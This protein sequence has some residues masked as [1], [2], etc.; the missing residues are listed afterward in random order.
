[1][2]FFREVAD[3]VKENEIC[4]SREAINR[5]LDQMQKYQ[6]KI[7]SYIED[8]YVEFLPNL[9]D[10]QQFL[11]E[12][13]RLL[14]DVDQFKKHIDDSQYDLLTATEEMEQQISDLHEAALG[15]KTSYKILKIDN[16]FQKLIGL[17]NDKKYQQIIGIVNEIK[18]LL[19]DPS[20]VI[21]KR[22]DCFENMKIKFLIENELL[23][24]NLTQQLEL[25]IQLN[26]KNFRKTKSVTV[27]ITTNVDLLHE[28]IISLFNCKYNPR[29][30]WEFLLNN[31]LE[32]II[33]K[34]VSLE[35]NEDSDEFSSVILSFSTE[36]VA[37]DLRPTYQ[38][39]FKN[40]ETV[41]KGLS[42]MNIS[43]ND[44]QC[45]FSMFGEYSKEKFLNLLKNNCLA[46]SL[47]ETIDEMNDST[48]VNDVL[49][50]NKFLTDML[51]F[52][53]DDQELTDFA[54]QIEILFKN[55][56]CT[57]ILDSAVDIM[58]NN[59]Q[60][61]VLINETDVPPMLAGSPAVF[62]KCM[63]SKSTLV[64]FFL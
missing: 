39:V 29:H 32:P 45:V 27:K 31:I 17:K 7:R 61:M 52:K 48:I 8:H 26:E 19:F 21:L 18:D 53:E 46:H 23:V 6:N 10:N 14:D 44:D 11:D 22:L 49:T 4:D 59:L 42:N 25:L 20:D 43:I 13:S 56:F 64:S 24:H 34:P 41:I 54:S 3:L 57:K 33:V 35:V 12:G 60:D 55:R 63:V 51:F 1:M 50:L 62:P 15:L 5:L 58:R 36:N 2:S 40:I 16:L 9:T 47:P 38:I 30:M 37:D 28:T